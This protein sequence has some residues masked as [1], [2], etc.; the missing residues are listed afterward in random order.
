[1]VK[2]NSS[3]YTMMGEVEGKGNEVSSSEIWTDERKFLHH[4]A[5]RGTEG[6]GVK[7]MQRRCRRYKEQQGCS[8]QI[9][10]NFRDKCFRYKASHKTHKLPLLL[11][12]SSTPP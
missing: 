4:K 12:V 1:M 6:D 11:F 5:H 2:D 8:V 9:S 7:P 3:G 10:N